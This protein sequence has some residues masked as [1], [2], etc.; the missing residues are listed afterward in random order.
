MAVIEIRPPS[1]RDLIWFGLLLL[2]A[3]G[4]LGAVI[5]WKSGALGW[6]TTTWVTG[7]AIVGFYYLAPSVQRPLYM[8]WMYAAY[9]V[10]WVVSHVVLAAIFFLVLTPIGWLVRRVSHDPLLRYFDPAATTYWVK[11]TAGEDT[12]QYFRQF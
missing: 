4:V 2:I 11:R 5:F 7:A 6:A 1:R 8:T 3:F 10:G 9:P 12:R